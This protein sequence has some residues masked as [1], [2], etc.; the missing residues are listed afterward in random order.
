M[1][2]PHRRVVDKNETQPEHLTCIQYAK[3]LQYMA[4]LSKGTNLIEPANC[5]PTFALI[6]HEYYD[7]T[8]EMIAKHD[9]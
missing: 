8:Y 9:P 1:D 7:I 3:V 2:V 6:L 5:M 4:K